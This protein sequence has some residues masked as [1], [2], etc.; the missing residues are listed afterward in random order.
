M[1]KATKDNCY[2]LIDSFILEKGLVRDKIYP[3][4]LDFSSMYPTYTDLVDIRNDYLGIGL[5]IFFRYKNPSFGD[6]KDVT[7]EIF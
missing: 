1:E 7:V 4:N 3:T 6:P 5:N 2:K